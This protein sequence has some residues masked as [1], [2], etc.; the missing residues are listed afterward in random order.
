MGKGRREGNKEINN[1][2]NRSRAGVYMGAPLFVIP[3]SRPLRLRLLPPTEH[4]GRPLTRRLSLRDFSHHQSTAA[5]GVTQGRERAR[6]YES[7]RER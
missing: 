4:T 5:G 1:R 2:K 6:E 3:P 7:T